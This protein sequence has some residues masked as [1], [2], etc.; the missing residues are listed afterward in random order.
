MVLRKVITYLEGI[1]MTDRTHMTHKT[2]DKSFK[3][4]CFI[5]S[6]EVINGKDI[7]GRF[8]CSCC[9]EYNEV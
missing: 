9:A 1:N 7:K 5:C 6:E 8:V 4:V 2:L 3:R